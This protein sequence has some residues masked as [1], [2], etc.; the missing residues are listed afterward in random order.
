MWIGHVIKLLAVAEE[1]GGALSVR[2]YPA[3]LPTTHPLAAVRESY[4]AVVVE[5]PSVGRLMFYGRGAGGTPTASAVLGDVI[6]AAVN[7]RKGTHASLGTLVRMPRRS[8]DQLTSA[9]YLN[10]E[11]T[12]QPGVLAAVANT[13]GRHSVSIRSM[14]QE[15]LGGDARI[16][17]IT[18]AAREASMALCLRELRRLGAVKR[19]VSVLRVVEDH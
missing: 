9:F 17:F 6:D 10:L 7:L 11:V 4:N 13:F 14:E 8:A 19:I 18:H 2:V 5:G 16:I 3:M 12:D 15:G 1:I